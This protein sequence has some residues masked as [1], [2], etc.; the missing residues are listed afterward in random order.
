MTIFFIISA[1]DQAHIHKIGLDIS[2]NEFFKTFS[3]IKSS[4]YIHIHVCVVLK[5]F[6][7]SF[8]HCNEIKFD[9][10]KVHMQNSEKETNVCSKILIMIHELKNK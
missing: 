6:S 2:G 3:N 8:L 5:I 1:D 10:D 9:K 4:K 7:D